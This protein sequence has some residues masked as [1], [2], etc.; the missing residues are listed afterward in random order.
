MLIWRGVRQGCI[1]RG[2]EGVRPLAGSK[3][4]KGMSSLVTDG[5][6]RQWLFR[7]TG[8]V[9]TL[10]S[11]AEIG[12]LSAGTGGACRGSGESP[13]EKFWDCNL[14]HFWPENGSQPCTANLCAFLKTLTME[15]CFHAF[16]QLFDNWNGVTGV[17]GFKPPF[18]IYIF[19]ELCV[20]KIYCPSRAPILIKS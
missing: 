1:C 7:K 13:S 12:V 19:L 5:I 15:R 6:L 17:E 9:E 8:I 14:V 18:H 4:L 16:R 10:A 3:V 20:C 11:H 2:L